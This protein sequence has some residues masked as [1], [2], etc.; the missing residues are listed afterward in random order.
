VLLAG[1]GDGLKVTVRGLLS[2]CVVLVGVTIVVTD[3]MGVIKDVTDWVKVA[4]GGTVG[5]TLPPVVEVAT[6]GSVYP[7]RVAWDGMV[8]FI[9]LIAVLRLRLVDI[10]ISFISSMSD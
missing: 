1:L 9:S 7:G 3:W 10:K 8:S 2:N 4:W 5:V 6:G